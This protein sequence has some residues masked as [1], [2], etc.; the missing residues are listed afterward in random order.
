MTNKRLIKLCMG[1][2]GMSRNAARLFHRA[3]MEDRAAVGDGPS[4]R[5]IYYSVALMLSTYNDLHD[6]SYAVVHAWKI[7]GDIMVRIKWND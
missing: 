1:H 4:N 7:P 2:C 3:A 5:E 6:R